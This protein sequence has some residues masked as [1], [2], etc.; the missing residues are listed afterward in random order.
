MRLIIAS[1]EILSIGTAIYIL[2]SYPEF[3][4][5]CLLPLAFALCLPMLLRA[6]LDAKYSLFYLLFLGAS[7][8]RYI[9]HPLLIALVKQYD[10]VAIATSITLADMN[11][12]VGLMVYEI[13]VCTLVILYIWS[14]SKKRENIHIYQ[15]NKS[16]IVLPKRKRIYGLIK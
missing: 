2:A 10:E 11:S 12:A 3:S 1:G 16:A 13:V 9:I 6:A 14:K 7:F 5:L 15:T 4:L 8:L